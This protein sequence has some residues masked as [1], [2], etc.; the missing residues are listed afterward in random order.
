MQLIGDCGGFEDDILN[1]FKTYVQY[2]TNDIITN[3]DPWGVIGDLPECCPPAQSPCWTEWVYR[4][5]HY[6]CY[7]D[8]YW[9]PVTGYRTI[10]KCEVLNPK[11]CWDRLRYCFYYEMYPSGPPLK[12]FRY[13][14]ESYISDSNCEQF[15]G[16]NQ[17]L[18]C[19]SVCD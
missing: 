16:P 5:G 15:G 4:Q 12:K 19:H 6:A 13:E 18:P 8:W 7:T 11:S 17:D 14:V 2:C 9:D 1:N 3:V 10:D